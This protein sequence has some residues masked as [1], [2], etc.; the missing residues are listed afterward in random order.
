MQKTYTPKK[1]DLSPKWFIVDAKDKVLGKLAV[2]IADTLRGKNKPTFT[3]NMDCGG[4]VIVINAEKIV[5]TGAKLDQ[6]MYYS[7]SGYKGGLKTV[8]ARKMLAEKPTKLIEEAVKS[9]LPKNRLQSVFM[10]KLK[11]Y[12]GEEHPH[13]AQQPETLE[14]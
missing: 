1:D 10:N 13:E 14:V 6:K 11:L 4:F 8:P 9:M 12:A 7:H 3:P 2:K 5:L